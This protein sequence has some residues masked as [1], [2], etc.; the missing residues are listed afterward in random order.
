MLV[1][2]EK[3]E[4]CDVEAGVGQGCV[5]SPT[6]FAIFIN[7]L[8]RAIS[9]SGVGIDVGGKKVAILLYADDIVIITDNAEDLKESMKIATKWGKQWR[10]SFNRN[11]RQ[12]VVF[13]QRKKRDQDWRLGVEK[14]DQ[15]EGYSTEGYLVPKGI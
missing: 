9:E 14:I 13:G 1:D 7:N 5:L 2:D 6:L 4:F 15:V 3:T 11:K 10:C 12:V 8:A